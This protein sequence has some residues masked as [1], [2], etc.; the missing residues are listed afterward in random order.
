MRAEYLQ[1]LGTLG[2]HH[3]DPASPPA[4]LRDPGDDYLV[5]LAVA[6]HAEAIVTGDHDLLDHVALEP[7]A[8]TAR[9]ACERLGLLDD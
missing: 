9:Q 2:S 6:A 3:T 4:T 7:P 5:A 1:L 8:M